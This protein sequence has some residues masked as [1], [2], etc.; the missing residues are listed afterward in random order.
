MQLPENQ[1]YREITY[2]T[3]MVNQLLRQLKNHVDEL[4]QETERSASLASEIAIAGRIQ[5]DLLVYDVEKIAGQYNIDLAVLLAPA[6]EIAGDF[7]CLAPRPHGKLL[8][9]VGDVSGKGIAAALA[10]KDCVNLI[11]TYGQDLTPA[12]LLQQMNADL[13]DRFSRQSM[14]V[15]LFCCLLD[16]ENGVLEHCDAG[17]E[18]PLL[19]RAGRTEGISRLDVE[20]NM[21]L[22]FLP[23]TTYKATSMKLEKNHT[24]LLYT[25]GLDGDL[26]KQ[27]GAPGLPLGVTLLS[28]RMLTS[29]DLQTKIHCINNLALRRQGGEPYDDITLLGISLEKSAY[30]SFLI[31]RSRTK[32]AM[33][34]AGCG[35]SLRKA[36][37]EPKPATGSAW[38]WMNGWATWPGMQEWTVTSLS[39]AVAIRKE[40]TWKSSPVATAPSIPAKTGTGRLQAFAVQCRR[41]VRHPY[42]P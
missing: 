25:D 24:L 37:P 29:V 14:F 27:D 8:F 12:Q 30:Q 18:T 9:A 1:R 7:Y 3:K 38:Y 32:W 40:S 28:N 42:H 36:M 41:R 21:A 10:A 26:H 34:S 13:F 39:A 4:Q 16:T 33:Q 31:P 5:Q 20:R 6:K 2:I 17:H 35:L 11:D 22:G 19:Y 15:T 23:D